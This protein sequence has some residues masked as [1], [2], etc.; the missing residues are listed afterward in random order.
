MTQSMM[1]QYRALTDRVRAVK[2]NPESRERRNQTQVEKTD[3]DVRRAIQRF[4]EMEAASRKEIDERAQRQA[5]IA[6]PDASE[7]EIKQIVQSDTQVFQQAVLGNRSERANRALGA[8]KQ[9]RREMEEVEKQL[10][11]LIEILSE[12]QELLNQQDEII[13]TVDK[14]MEETTDE[15]KAANGDLTV[16]TSKALSAR[17]KKWWCLGIC[18]TFLLEEGSCIKYIFL[19]RE[20][21]SHCR[22][23]RRRCSCLYHGK[24]RSKRRRRRRQQ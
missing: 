4:Q 18:G 9:R 15:M 14:Q 6:H 1:D 16:A 5:R 7:A 11:D 17:S 22:H 3:R 21:S 20:F 13:Q 19:T 10:L 2:R 24:P 12:T 8:H 23:Y